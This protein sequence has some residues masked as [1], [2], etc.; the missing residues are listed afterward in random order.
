MVRAAVGVEH[1]GGRVARRLPRRGDGRQAQLAGRE[2]GERVGRGY[3]G[4]GLR[5]VA[6]EDVVQLPAG[7]RRIQVG[8]L[9]GHRRGCRLDPH[10]NTGVE[11][12]REHLPRVVRPVGE[13]LGDCRGGGLGRQRAGLPGAAERRCQ[14]Q[15]FPVVVPQ[16]EAMVRRYIVADAIEKHP[17]RP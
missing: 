5:P 9:V 15:V 12:G 7:H 17:A 16:G 4:S 2:A 13:V 14:P 1:A 10:G 11:H 6:G 8:Q 3:V